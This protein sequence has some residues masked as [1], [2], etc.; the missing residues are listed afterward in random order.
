MYFF[1]LALKN[2]FSRKSSAIM[3]V[4]ISLSITMLMIVNALF[5]GTDDG[6]KTVFKDSFTG[7]I[8]IREKTKDNISLFGNV[9]VIDNSV[10]PTQELSSLHDIYDYISSLKEVDK[11]TF[12]LSSFSL[13]EVEGRKFTSALFGI[14]SDEYLEMM[15]SI[16]ITDGEV[17]HTDE[18][19]CLVSQNWADDFYHENHFRIKVGDEVQLIYSDGNTFRIRAVPVKGIYSYPA[20]NSVLDKIVLVDDATLRSLLGRDY[21]YVETE[22]LLD[23]ENVSFDEDFDFDSLFEEN[24]DFEI[25]ESSARNA[26]QIILDLNDKDSSFAENDVEKVASDDFLSTSWDFVIIN[27]KDGVNEKNVIRKINRFARQNNYTFEAMDWRHAAGMSAQYVFWLRIILIIG[28]AVILFAGLIVVNNSLVV[29]IVDRTREIGTM[30]AIGA[31]KKNISALCMRETLILTIFSGICAC[32]LSSLIILLFRSFPIHLSNPFFIQ[33]FGGEYIIP[34]YKLKNYV[35]GLG[36]SAG[37]G[38]ISWMFPVFEALKIMPVVAMKG[39]K[40]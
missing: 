19:G 4:F 17:F 8:V 38:L 11:F 2:V 23:D 27:L 34:E 20:E 18:K 31:N 10:I 6:I 33:L 3:I 12:Q 30:R 15:N 5:D 26:E 35:L 21:L 9:S 28:I 14:R 29:N 37:L 22:D 25:K 13:L 24:S 40:L 7:D 32:A 16:Q 1:R 39:G 36:L